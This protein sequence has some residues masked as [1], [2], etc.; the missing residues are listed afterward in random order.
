MPGTRGREVAVGNAYACIHARL[1]VLRYTR[2]TRARFGALVLARRRA[3]WRYALV[4]LVRGGRAGRQRVGDLAGLQRR[5]LAEDLGLACA[6][7]RRRYVR[8]GCRGRS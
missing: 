2:R 7:D 3:E 6:V 4:A 5:R 8:C 1:A